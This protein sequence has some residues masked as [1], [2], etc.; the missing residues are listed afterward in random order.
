M[1]K[2]TLVIQGGGFRSAFSCGVL[3]AFL[4][5]R[6][7]P[8][9]RYVA[10]SGGT[11]AVSYFLGGQ[12]KQCLE[13]MVLLSEDDQFLDNAIK[14]LEIAL[15]ADPD[16]SFGWKQASIAYHRMNNNGMTYYSTAQHFLLSGNIRGA[17]VNAKKALDILPKGSPNWI[18]SQDIMVVT[19]SHLSDDEKKRRKKNK[20]ENREIRQK[21][22]Q[23]GLI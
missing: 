6:Y 9:D 4:V 7:F 21:E 12:Y 13:A 14:N 11:M 1:H 22:R 18:K 16:D 8:F 20:K 17:M 5:N 23:R 10:V 3:D 15:D 19:E 2:K